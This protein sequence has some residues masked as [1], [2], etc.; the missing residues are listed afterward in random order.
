[1]TA[2][3]LVAAFILGAAVACLWLGGLLRGRAEA[4]R[5]AEARGYQR[6]ASEGIQ[7][8]F[9]AGWHPGMTRGAR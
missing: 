8:G 5:A 9:D 6:R 1:M 2:L 7:A 4:I 3:H